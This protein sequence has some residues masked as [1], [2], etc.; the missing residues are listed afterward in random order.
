M[1]NQRD[2][3]IIR[4]QDIDAAIINAAIELSDDERSVMNKTTIHQRSQVGKSYS[5]ATHKNN[6][7][8]TGEGKHIQFKSHSS[9]ALYQQQ[10]NTP[11]G[12]YD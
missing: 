3:N 10:D 12:T 4:V 6:N 7:I 5:T 1:N 9:I 8:F 2:K 11:M